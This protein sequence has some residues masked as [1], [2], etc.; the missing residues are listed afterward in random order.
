[1]S[2]GTLPPSSV[3]ARPHT[4]SP[5]RGFLFCYSLHDLVYTPAIGSEHKRSARPGAGHAPVRCEHS[6]Q[7]AAIRHLGPPQAPSGLSRHR[8]AANRDPQLG[9]CSKA[10]A[11]WGAGPTRSGRHQRRAGW[12]CCNTPGMSCAH[13][14]AQPFLSRRMSPAGSVLEVPHDHTQSHMDSMTHHGLSLWAQ[15]RKES[16]H[17]QAAIVERPP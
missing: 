2:V 13:L 17:A 12:M 15:D 9:S 16:A 10:T 7:S 11:C 5:T 4:T 1:M 6:P 14:P 3:C 8:S